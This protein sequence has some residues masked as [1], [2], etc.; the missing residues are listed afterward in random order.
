[1]R[2]GLF[3]RFRRPLADTD[4]ANMAAIPRKQRRMI[5]VG[6]QSGLVSRVDSSQLDV[7]YDLYARSVRDLGTPVFPRRYFQLLLERFG[8]ACD[9]LTIWHERTAVA[10]VM[11]FY[12][13]DTV[14]PYY[15]GSRRD[16]FRYAVNDFMYWELMRHAR[17][18]GVRWFDFGRSKKG[19]GAYDFKSHWGFE[20]EPLRYRIALRG[21]DTVPE[22]SMS[23]DRVQFLRRAWQRLPLP[24]TK[25]LGPFFIRRF[26][27]LYT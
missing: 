14:L 18:R 7:F 17:A 4:E 3:Y 5:R 16:Y 27:A 15:A 23:S 20:P 26:G 21:N 19:T 12:F 8:S 6:Q 10:G 24:V 13:N 2:E 22:R 11:S 25:V 9:L 1:V